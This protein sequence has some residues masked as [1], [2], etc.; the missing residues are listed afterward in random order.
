MTPAIFVDKNYERAFKA[1]TGKKIFV[2]TILTIAAIESSW[3]DGETAKYAN[4]YFGIKHFGTWPN[5]YKYFRA[6]ATVQDSFDD[7]VEFL[8][9]NSRYSYA[10]EQKNAY[11]QLIAIAEAGYNGTNQTDIQAYIN[12]ITGVYDLVQPQ[13]TRIVQKKEA[14]ESNGKSKKGLAFLLV[15]LALMYNRQ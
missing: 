14:D 3:G 1:R 2:S 10:L 13:V 12:L 9:D 7:F 8:Y 5:K 15:G 4:N 11:K 6:Y